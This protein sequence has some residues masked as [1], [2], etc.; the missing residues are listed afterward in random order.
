VTSSSRPRSRARLAGLAAAAVA[1][2]ALTPF[3]GG[4]AAAQEAAAPP[5]APAVLG[6]VNADPVIKDVVLDWRA[7]SGAE[8]Y[9]VELGTDE[10]WSD[11]AVWTDTTA[12]TE[13]ALPAWLPDASYLWRVAAVKGGV[14]GAWSQDGTFTRGWRDR[15]VLVAPA[16]GAALPGRPTFSWTPVPG[17]SAYQLQVSTSSTFNGSSPLEADPTRDQA[18]PVVDTCFT[19]RTSVTPFTEKVS[20]REDNPGAC[21]FS[22][23]GTGKTVY[24][25]VRA[26]DRYVDGSQEVPTSPASSAGISYLPPSASGTELASDCPGSTPEPVVT[27]T[28]TPT[29]TAT[30]TATPSA[31][32]SAAPT[33]TATPSPTAAP[34]P[35]EGEGGGCAPT[36]PVDTGRWTA[37]RSLTTTYSASEGSALGVVGQGT[38]PAYCTT[39]ASPVCDDFP[40]LSWPADAGANRYRV[41]VSLTDDFSNVQRIVETSATTWTPTDGW[42][43]SSVGES[44]YYLVQACNSTR[45]GPVPTADANSD[46]VPDQVARQTFRK[47][48]PAAKT[49]AAK[50]PQSVVEGVELRWEDYAKTRREAP[51]KTETAG[52]FA[53]RLEVRTGGESFAQGTLV[54]D[55]VVDGSRCQPDGSGSAGYRRDGVLD[56]DDSASTTAPGAT[57]VVSYVSDKTYP[58]ANV[59]WRVQALDPSGNRLPWSAPQTI[60][61]T[62]PTFTVSPTEGLAPDATVVVTFSEPVDGITSSTVRLRSTPSTITPVG[63][64]KSFTLKANAMM[65]AGAPYTVEASPAIT[66]KAGNAYVPKPVGLKVAAMVDDLSAGLR[67]LGGWS[68]LSASGA[69]GGTYVRALPTPSAWAATH[70]LVYGSGAE[71]KGCVGPGNGIVEVW[72]GPTR[73]ARVDTYRNSTSC[74]V[75]LARVSFP[76]GL[77]VVEV[78]GM[79]QKSGLSEGTA[80]AVDAVTALP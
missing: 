33:A 44:Y 59:H 28:A 11:D 21:V 43:E 74:G 8:S 35:G 10:T 15:P 6:P 42:R 17:A 22:V 67:L 71:L 77:H 34:I 46:G 5:A 25:R 29:A 63:D 57:D 19:S 30:A 7:V 31:D 36:H 72:D 37:F 2:G 61:A 4:S 3:A 73:L 68:R 80:M 14:Q 58:D 56:C 50:K 55:V 60:D 12:T 54:E 16:S 49:A 62:P 9:V 79:G 52:A 51:G 27:A 75:V 48:S 66:D 23:L 41:Y 32:P 13:L 69:V 38:L 53:Y 40:T 76:P 45:C 70:T 1:A 65:Y 26:L 20:A 64:G 47:K 39:A 24:W 78:R 18:S